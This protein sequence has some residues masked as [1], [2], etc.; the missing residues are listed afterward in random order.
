[1]E[2]FQTLF[3]GLTDMVPTGI[4]LVGFMV[5]LLAVRYLLRRRYESSLGYRFKLQMTTLVLS[6]VGLLA[7]I[8]ALPI[9]ETTTG[10]LL[11]LLGLLLSAAIA[12]SATTFVGNVMAGLMQRA[13]RSFRPGDFI[14]VGDHFG[15]VTEQ[16]LFHVEIQTEDRDLTTM[17]NLYLV[18]NPVKVIRSSGTLITAEVSLGYDVPHGRVEKLLLEAAGDAALEEPFVHIMELGDFSITYRVA[19]LLTEVKSLLSTRS[20]LRQM[21]LDRLHGGGVEI[22]SP[23]FMNQRVLAQDRLFIPEREVISEAKPV[24]SKLPEAVVFD[25]A[26]EAESLSKLQL[27]HEQIGK[28]LAEAKKLLDEATDEGERA[29][30]EKEIEGLIRRQERLVQYIEERQKEG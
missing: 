30:I 23:S 7:V 25:K 28:D 8:I 10:Q 27:R 3:K 15:R 17:P 21:V 14:R 5:V 24:A 22:V 13:V 11:S 2:I 16:G 19:G 12:L 26:E 4:T 1:M 9:S 29:R 6:F 20:R 18:T